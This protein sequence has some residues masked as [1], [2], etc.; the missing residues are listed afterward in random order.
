MVLGQVHSTTPA[1]FRA[2]ATPAPSPA[3]AAADQDSVE[4]TSEVRGPERVLW[5]EAASLGLLPSTAAVPGPLGAV[6]SEAARQD[7][8]NLLEDLTSRGYEF[9]RDH[10]PQ[11]HN[12]FS[13]QPLKAEEVGQ[14]ILASEMSD[15]MA[16]SGRFDYLV[17][18]EPGTG[19][20][21][22]DDL[23]DLFLLENLETLDAPSLTTLRGLQ[24]NGYKFLFTERPT[25]DGGAV[26]GR[27]YSGHVSKRDVGLYGAFRALSHPETKDKE[28]LWV[29]QGA[30]DPHRLQS[31]ADLEPLGYFEMKQPWSGADD[32]ALTIREL[33]EQGYTFVNGS[34][35]LD[36]LAAYDRVKS[37]HFHE[38]NVGVLGH[39]AKKARKE[40]I[41]RP[42]FLDPEVVALNDFY[43]EHI[44][45]AEERGELDRA[46]ASFMVRVLA[47]EP[48]SVSL[49]ERWNALNRL[50]TLEKEL[51]PGA[52]ENLWLGRA[53][54]GVMWMAKELAAGEPFPALVEEY[55][56]VRQ[57]LAPSVAAKALSF[58]RE[59]LR[60]RSATVEDYQR[61]RED[62]TELASFADD[63][64]D[65]P[66]AYDA[67]R[68]DLTPESYPER[69]ALLRRL[70]IHY[71]DL[72][73]ESRGFLDDVAPFQQAVKD[74]QHL[75]GHRSPGQ[76]LE[77]AANQ[78]LQLHDTLVPLVG[79]EASRDAFGRMVKAGQTPDE[80]G[81]ELA[82]AM[83]TLDGARGESEKER[84]EDYRA[85]L[86]HRLLG[87]SL[88][89]AADTLATLH[90]AIGSRLGWE[91]GRTALAAFHQRFERGELGQEYPAAR[92]AFLEEQTTVLDALGG[93]AEDY[94]AVGRYRLPGH[95]PVEA[96]RLLEAIKG[97]WPEGQ[98][99]QGPRAL[100]VR[101]C[102]EFLKGSFGDRTPDQVGKELLSSLLATG[103]PARAFVMTRL[104]PERQQEITQDMEAIFVG[105]FSLDI[106]Q[107]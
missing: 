96:A 75:L 16:W 65:V 67:L 72:P 89:D 70:T 23:Q 62:L 28:L 54:H 85:L 33:D 18:R 41:T 107:F 83:H 45:P 49:E 95:S 47:S 88:E 71:R 104:G 11:H 15:R 12:S 26:A 93:S 27:P 74:Y 32:L 73:K 58:F 6:L 2:A 30:S 82:R 50:H 78:L 8:Q 57:K 84:G 14:T 64:K 101:L 98:Q 80:L 106:N 9:R 56:T 91:R 76:S 105:D 66:A 21:R 25:D 34:D 5:K 19:G 90:Q 79:W 55:A 43:R 40:Q 48:P 1:L 103:Q 61:Q 99:P 81:G 87:Q 31:E 52:D 100:Y 20:V 68:P 22:V 37:D 10:S 59:G 35:P 102:N 69:V 4:L 3:D 53:G 39:G 60:A 51:D 77:A 46:F 97:A 38:I 44:Q 94:E 36:P 63:F 86:R 24:E 17:V 7:L 13:S 92:E 29:R 42:E